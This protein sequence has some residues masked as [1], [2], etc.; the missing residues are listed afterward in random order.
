MEENQDTNTRYCNKCLHFDADTKSCSAF[1]NGIP[2][3]LL[4][5]KIKHLSKFPE[6]TG[7]EVFVD[8]REY[9]ISQG[10][11]LHPMEGVDDFIIED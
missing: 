8:A 9:W 10:L 6:Q 1:P 7:T 3:A 5:G 11:E 4:A 2:S